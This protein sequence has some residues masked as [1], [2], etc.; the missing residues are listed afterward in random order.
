MLR[1]SRYN[2]EF[3]I[4]NLFIALILFL[5]L[6]AESKANY[7]PFIKEQLL[8]V[9]E[10]ADKNVTQDKIMSIAVKQESLYSQTLDEILKN[11]NDFINKS[12]VY[13]SEIF[14]L[15]KIIKLNKRL[16]NKYAVIR[17]EVLVKSYKL[18]NAQNRMIRDVL[19][20]LDKYSF[21]EFQ[22]YMSKIFVKNQEYNAQIIGVDYSNILNINQPSRTLQEA[23]ENIKDFYNLIEVNTDTLK[24]LSLFE[25]KM[26]RLNKYSNINLIN[27][28]VSINN[29]TVAR[30]INSYINPY[31]LDVVKL[32]FILL[33]TVIVYIVRKYLYQEI[34]AYIYTIKSLQKY[35]KNIL[36]SIRKPLELLIIMINIELSVYIYN[37]FVGAGALDKFFTIVYVLLLTYSIYKVVNVISSIKIHDIN[38]VDKQIKSEVINVGI[39]IVNFI[40]ML[41][42]VLVILH[43]AGADLTT[44]LSG[45]GIGGFAVALAAKDSLANFFGTLSILLSDV[46]SQGD[47]IAVN[48]QEGTVVEIGLRVTTLRTFDNAIIAIPNSILTNKDV[49]NWN[50]RSLGRRIKMSLG[51]KYDS[52]RENIKKAIEEIR[53]M[54]DKHPQIATKNTEYDYSKH[55][56]AKLVSKDD[57]MGIKRNLLVYLDEF[58]GSSINILIYCFSKSVN[59]N[60]W[61]ETKE[62]VMYKIMEIFEKNSLEFAFPSMSI[63]HENE[64]SQTS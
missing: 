56:S 13:D 42:G 44:V 16:G 51:I 40:I 24:Y 25:K 27:P 38:T 7:S 11:K 19:R 28:V 49:K 50:K 4:K 35:S 8:L 12:R 52:K 9:Q 14:A 29:T 18:L 59:W 33:I 15:E 46:F 61:L 41:I 43:F 45:L 63:Y 2:K 54:L 21:E 47:W 23:K 57:E 53:Y 26:Y 62:D 64:H 31:G 30:T 48:G 39:K 32:I 3:T 6:L 20:G 17:D 60:E 55:K 5:P 1:A 10:M 36:N 37:D 22:A 34:E 58:S